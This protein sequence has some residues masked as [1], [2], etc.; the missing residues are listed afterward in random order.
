[1]IKKILAIL[2]ISSSLILWALLVAVL[3]GATDEITSELE[4]KIN[5]LEKRQDNIET[6]LFKEIKK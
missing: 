4:H 2:N 6:F 3:S 5:A 1:M